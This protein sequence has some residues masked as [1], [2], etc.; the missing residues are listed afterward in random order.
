M[1]M[2]FSP[3]WDRLISETDISKLSHIAAIA[4]TTRQ[5]VSRKKNEN[6]FP[7]EWAYL[8][9]RKYGI[10]TEWILTGKGP[11]R[12]EEIR[13]TPY[14]NPISGNIDVWLKEKVLN[15]PEYSGYFK[16]HFEQSFP[17]YK[18]WIK[19]REGRPSDDNISPSSK[20]A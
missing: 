4:K 5:Y 19:R 12:L 2:E 10:L 13:S 15:E 16:I 1:T 6:R 8:I 17:D 18:E 20:V 14:L 9:A 7:I 3:I 11:K